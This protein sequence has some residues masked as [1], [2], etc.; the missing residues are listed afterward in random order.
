MSTVAVQFP[1]SASTAPVPV[2]SYSVVGSDGVTASVPAGGPY[3]VTLTPTAAIG[4]AYTVTVLTIGT[5]G[6]TIAT[7]PVSNS[8]TLAAPTVTVQIAG[9]PVI[10]QTS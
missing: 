6:S 2:A 3:T 1:L 10:S 7:S 5:D 9:T 4:S 8:I